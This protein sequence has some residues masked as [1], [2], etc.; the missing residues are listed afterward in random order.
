ML[1]Q[2]LSIK[3]LEFILFYY[4]NFGIIFATLFS[5]HKITGVKETAHGKLLIRI[6]NDG[7][8]GGDH[9]YYRSKCAKQSMVLDLK[10][11]E[12]EKDIA[13]LLMISL[14]N[15]FIKKIKN[16]KKTSLTF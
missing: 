10:K 4:V 1:W 3:A 12:S 11:K 7:R 5:C 6:I 8:D 16:Q 2:S 13:N 15:R 9:Q 14:I